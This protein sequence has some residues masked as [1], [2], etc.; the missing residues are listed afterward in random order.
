MLDQG[1]EL[2]RKGRTFLFVA[3]ETRERT[4]VV[5]CRPIDVG[6]KQTVVD[7]AVR[8]KD[9]R[10]ILGMDNLVLKTIA[11]LDS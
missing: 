11:Q 5:I 3:G 10:L 7:V 9:G 1:R 6:T 2:G 4:A 8:E